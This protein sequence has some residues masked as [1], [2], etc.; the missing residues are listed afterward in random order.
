MRSQRKQQKK[1]RVRV[2]LASSA[3]RAWDRCGPQ[4]V[5]PRIQAD[6]SEEL[7]LE[8][9]IERAPI[10]GSEVNEVAA[11]LNNTVKDSFPM[12]IE[13][14]LVTRPEVQCTEHRAVLCERP[15]RSKVLV[16]MGSDRRIFDGAVERRELV[17]RLDAKAMDRERVDARTAPCQRDCD[18][19]RGSDA[20]HSILMLLIL[21]PI[22]M[23]CTTG[24][25]AGLRRPKFAYMPSR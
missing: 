12:R 14:E 7:G 25:S 2:N 10:T 22:L 1:G 15:K 11:H 21:S 8:G 16:Q 18:R 19:E 5:A 3:S 9:V 13:R 6:R 23:P 24:I 4:V 17:P 20:D